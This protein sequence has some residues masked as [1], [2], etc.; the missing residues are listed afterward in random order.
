MLMIGSY[1]TKEF[2]LNSLVSRKIGALKMSSNKLKFIK[3]IL[4]RIYVPL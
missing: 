1:E 2:G 3:Q 4:K